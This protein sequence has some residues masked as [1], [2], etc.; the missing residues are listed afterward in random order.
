[1]TYPSGQ[2]I[3]HIVHY[4]RLQSLLQHGYLYSDK[5]VRENHLEGSNIGFQHLKD[6]RLNTALQSYPDLMV[7]ACVPFYYCPRSVMLY[8]I[9]MAS[10]YNSYNRGQRE[11]VH[12]EFDLTEA[13][14]WA[15][16]NERRLAL[17]DRNAS[18]RY[19]EDYCTVPGF[20]NIRWD[21]VNAR[22]WSDPQVK[23]RKAAEFLI[24]HSFPF[25][26]VERL[27]I[28]SLEPVTQRIQ[29]MLAQTEYAAK[30]QNCPGWYY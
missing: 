26:L 15:V 13:I 3:Y 25:N 1:M 14:S 2:K 7:G 8:T 23:E 21:A 28:H 9:N 4:D 30:L 12:L 6:R 29:K 19:F 27:G 11:I 10:P 16:R 22:Y 5:Y 18:T 20:E 24:E 17:T